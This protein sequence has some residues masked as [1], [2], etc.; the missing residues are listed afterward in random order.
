MIE[1]DE[2]QQF[3]LS[4]RRFLEENSSTA[5]VRK[6]M[7]TPEG[8]D[9]LVWKDLAD[10]VGVLGLRIPN[11]W[12]GIGFG[13]RELGIVLE[14]M[15]RCLYCGPFYGSCVLAA[16]ALLHCAS[17]EQ[18]ARLLPGI[19]DGSTIGTLAIWEDNRDCW[20]LALT[21]ASADPIDAGHAKITGSKHLVLD[22]GICN[23]L[24]VTAIH[25]GQLKLY[26]VNPNSAAVHIRSLETI[27]QTRKLFQIDF[28]SAIGANLC[29]ADI[30]EKMQRMLDEA[31][32]GLANEMI[33]GAQTLLDTAVD[34]AK[35]RMQFG[36]QIGS[37]QAIKHKCADLLL[38]IEL[39]RSGV[40]KATDA[41]DNND[42]TTPSLASLAKSAASD[43]YMH[44]A[45][46]CI[47][48][49]GGIGFTW[50]NDTHLWFKRAK[51]NEVFLGT[52]LSHRERYIALSRT[53]HE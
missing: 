48:I 38:E 14:E 34:Y 39:A 21:K 31:T 35:M 43:A 46:E 25:D 28:D 33:G 8:F 51:S 27:D 36:R 17:D 44:A 5:E 6:W 45:S 24:L 49:H 40:L 42:N 22:A 7:E 1:S 52:P 20:D 11:S 23:L 2:Q 37:F 12:G 13:H 15:G 53:S 47:Q 4:V 18:K 29:S 3:R 19:A 30:T 9:Q 10:Q 32:V 50:D 16:G 41:I 26:S